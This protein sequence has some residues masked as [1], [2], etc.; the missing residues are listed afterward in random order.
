MNRKLAIEILQEMRDLGGL[1]SP[2]VHVY[3][4]SVVLNGEFTFDQLLAIAW[5]VENRNPL[6][7]IE[8]AA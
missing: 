1:G 5:C 8:R 2:F 3:S 7:D 4:H 6:Q